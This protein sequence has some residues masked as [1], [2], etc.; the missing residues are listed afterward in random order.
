[1]KIKYVKKVK[2]GPP[3]VLLLPP[4]WGGFSTVRA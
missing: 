4:L 3:L 2:Y 1:M